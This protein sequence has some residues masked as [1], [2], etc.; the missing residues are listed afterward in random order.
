MNWRVG[1]TTPEDDV[2][3]PH[4]RKTATPG[5]DDNWILVPNADP[6]LKWFCANNMAL[7]S[8]DKQH[9]LFIWEVGGLMY[10]TSN[11]PPT[12]HNSGTQV[13]GSDAF[14]LGLTIEDIGN[15]VLRVT[16]GPYE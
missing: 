12:P 11:G 14:Y 6:V 7:T 16:A 1:D 3:I 4:N 2:A 13:R 15:G 8:S 9:N 5:H 10:W